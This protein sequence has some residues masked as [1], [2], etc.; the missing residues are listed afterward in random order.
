MRP[1]SVIL[2]LVVAGT[3]YA[4][5]F[6][7]DRLF[8]LAGREPAAEAAA[9]PPPE[10]GEAAVAAAPGGPAPVAVVVQRSTAEEVQDLVLLRGQTEASRMVEVRA[11][12]SGLVT[13]E[14]LRRGAAVEAGDV[15]CRLDPG[16]RADSLAEAEARLAE[17]RAR[18]PEAEARIPAAEARLAEARGRVAAA[19]AGVTEAN[20]RLREAEINA[21]AAERLSEG[22]FAAET[23][24]AG[25]EA[26]LEAA[27]AGISTAEAGL[28]GAEAGV[29]AAAADVDGAAAAVESARAGI[30]SAQAAVAGAERELERLVILAPFDGILEADTAELGTLLQPGGLC[31]TVLLLD[32]IKLVAF[33][34]ETELNAARVG[35][36][37]AGRL[38]T[39]EEVLGEVAFVARSADPATR[40]FRTEV[41]IPNGD[42]AIR[43]GQ[44]V[45]VVIAGDGAMAHLVPRSALTLNDDGELGLRLNEGGVT[46]FAPVTVLR[47]SREGVYVGGL[48]ETA[49]VIVLGQ[50]YVREGVPLAV[51]YR[52]EQTQ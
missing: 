31:G 29:T 41:S 13:S 44:T 15:M 45:E 48:P 25:A 30:Q 6:E 39:G 40:T 37:A 35:A 10:A 52:E 28:E 47:D 8:A 11:E 43:D 42:L 14:P 2:A 24:V 22:G 4:L 21:N 26:A 27:R 1:I 23:R 7:R 32:P 51:T 18:L 3:L 34:P 49:E 12:T 46:R 19:R 9:A 50:E 5:V 20:A 16:T 38:A 33:L 36:T 17:A